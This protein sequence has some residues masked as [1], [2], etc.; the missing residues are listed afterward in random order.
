MQYGLGIDLGTTQTAAAVRVDGRVEIVRLGGRRAEIPSLVFV[1]PDG[2]LLIGEA[3]ERRG[4]AE[5]G[6]LAREFKRRIGDPV[7]ILAGGVP[8]SAH[9]LTAKLLRHVLDTVIGLQDGPPAVLAVTHPANWGPYKREQLDQA[10]RLADT[11]PV[12]LRTEPEAAAL[13]HATARRIGPGETV[14]VYD[15]G[16]GTF[17]A[18]VLRRDGEGF[19]LL[20]EPEGIEQLGG[21]DF[22]EAVFGH[23][24]GV[25]GNRVEGLDPDEPDV[26]TALARL[27]RDCVEAKEALS[28]DTEV[29]IPVALPGVHTRVRLNRSELESMIAPAL[30]DTVAAMHRALRA[31]GVAPGD[32]EAVLLAGGSSRIPLIGQL[33]STAFDLPVVADPHPE[34]SIAMG[35]AVATA[36]VTGGV[37]PFTEAV[38]PPPRPA[39]DSRPAAE[40]SPAAPAAA[41]AGA[42]SGAGSGSGA[43]RST[44]TP[45]AAERSASAQGVPVS[46]AEAS[47]TTPDASTEVAAAAAPPVRP[48][49]GVPRRVAPPGTTQT[50]VTPTGTAQ[51]EV[52][53]TGTANTE[54]TPEV[55]G[56]ARAATRVR[57]G[58]GAG[59]HA[60]SPAGDATVR[61]ATVRDASVHGSAA[62]V[63]YTRGAASVPSAAPAAPSAVPRTQ[64]F[65]A[66]TRTFP[67]PTSPAP[68]V[69]GS[70][71]FASAAAGRTAPPITP[72]PPVSY[73]PVPAG[74]GEDDERPRRSG[75]M[76]ILVGAITLA[77]IAGT[78]ALVALNR[79]NGK[80]DA[81]AQTPPPS[82][83]ASAPPYPLDTML[84]Q[85]DTGGV[86]RP[87]L[88]S[89]VS[90][91][92]PGRT[93]RTPISVTGGDKVPEWSRDRKRV[94]VIR[95]REGRKNT[96]FVMDAKGGSPVKVV[97]D[98]TGGRVSW[99]PDGKRLA[100]ERVVDGSPQIFLITVGESEPTQ[101]TFQPGM[102]DDPAWSPLGGEL[103]YHKVV[104]EQRQIFVLNLN[105]PQEPGRPITDGASGPGVDP[106]WSRDGLKIA[107]T[108]LIGDETSGYDTSD[109]WVVG[110]DGK[111][112]TRVTT[113]KA[114]EM[115]PSW[116]PNGSW[117]A[118]ARGELEDQDI[119]IVKT[120]GSG[121][122]TLT[123]GAAREGHP[124]WS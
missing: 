94:A 42:G 117:L 122:K 109:I 33:L 111:N 93:D 3:A 85:V 103:A 55:T 115:D 40:P 76:L 107:Y 92:T 78:T 45:A 57:P 43:Q 123:T 1:R 80:K 29:M 102:K 38:A 113:N 28:F 5:P 119:V 18:A 62:P 7:P 9:A 95:Y 86:E 27:R 118:F 53:P 21:A 66:Q 14:A 67:Q 74:A 46:T 50:E 17:D 2:G 89:N 49:N 35:A 124:A 10:L 36:L 105:K 100:F 84:I 25:L 64:P 61:D 65:V 96:I 108:H 88:K 13:Q 91:L 101:L 20:G 48:T 26:V 15:L 44:A 106:N 98:V 81:G 73:P 70:Q 12:L 63:A 97:E 110:R 104:G 23:V 83:S 82:P 52:T 24:L 6:R 19:Q 22:D 32:L 37:S 90:L 51:T 39:A 112:P 58:N 68:A 41:A 71:V 114:R 79:Y 116:S 75:R 72:G 11:G 56:E 87:K 16:G 60:G 8:F 31:A 121:E 34:H 59:Q 4:Q 120:D 77:V 54:V 99:S 30:A 47:R 69:G